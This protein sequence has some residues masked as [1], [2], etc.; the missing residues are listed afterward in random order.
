M[1]S[2][3]VKASFKASQ[4]SDWIVAKTYSS[5]LR[6]LLTEFI[7]RIMT[8]MSLRCSTMV[9]FGSIMYILNITVVG[10]S[11]VIASHHRQFLVDST[12][13]WQYVSAQIFQCC[14][15]HATPNSEPVTIILLNLSSIGFSIILM[16]RSVVS[17]GYSMVFVMISKIQ[18]HLASTGSS[19]FTFHN[20]FIQ[21]I[22][23]S[24]VSN[25]VFLSHVSVVHYT[26]LSFVHYHLLLKLL[27]QLIDTVLVLISRMKTC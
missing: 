23:C 20:W 6:L 10:W 8:D 22:S 26:R 2:L 7:S 11:L 12:F 25:C 15:L 9:C 19:Y 21:F 13:L 5:S 14:H 18:L 17:M 1:V 24:Q 16:L 4:E 27:N 3:W